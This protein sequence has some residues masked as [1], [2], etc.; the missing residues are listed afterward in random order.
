MLKD[1]WIYLFQYMPAVMTGVGFGILIGAFVL[2]IL[3]ANQYMK[4]REDGYEEGREDGEHSGWIR[5]FIKGEDAMKAR[6]MWEG[7]KINAVRKSDTRSGHEQ[8]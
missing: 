4:G 5:G 7:K 3:G 2:G 1:F 6:L 8:G